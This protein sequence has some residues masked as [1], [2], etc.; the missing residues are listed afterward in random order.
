MTSGPQLHTE[1]PAS[2]ASNERS[3]VDQTAQLRPGFFALA[4]RRR[5][6]ILVVG[7][8]LGLFAGVGAVSQ[9]PVTYTSQASLF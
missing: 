2:P 4:I 5:W 1:R 9:L 7:A 6:R 8:V 3:V